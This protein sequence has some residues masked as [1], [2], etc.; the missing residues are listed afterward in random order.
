MHYL[1]HRIAKVL[2]DD[3]I[4]QA[5]RARQRKQLRQTPRHTAAAKPVDNPAGAAI[6]P[7]AA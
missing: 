3:R 5:R 2:M 6:N 7:K 1:D 4:E